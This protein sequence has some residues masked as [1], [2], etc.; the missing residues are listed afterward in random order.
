MRLSR[1]AL[2]LTTTPLLAT[3]LGVSGCFYSSKET[4]KV[5][6]KPVPVVVR[7]PDRVITYPEGR[8]EM[9]GDGTES[10]PYYW[11]WVPTGAHSL[12]PAPP[13]PIVQR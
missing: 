7:G 9:H 3:A 5:A 10:S 13:P 2:L 4:E 8:Y 6:T 1:R 11:V 12:P